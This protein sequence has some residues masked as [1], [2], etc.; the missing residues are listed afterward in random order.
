MKYKILLNSKKVLTL[1]FEF[2]FHFI[3]ILTTLGYYAEIYSHFYFN[4]DLSKWYDNSRI[5][6]QIQTQYFVLKQWTG[7]T[8]YVGDKVF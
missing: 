3:N 2:K 1:P 5:I 7:N 8:N 6:I 4:A